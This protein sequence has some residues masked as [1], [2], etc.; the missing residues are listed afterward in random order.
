VA[1]SGLYD[2]DIS[3]CHLAIMRQL[4]VRLGVQMP[5]LDNYLANKAD[6]RKSIAQNIYQSIDWGIVSHSDQVKSV[7]AAIL[8][9]AYGGK[10][11]TSPKVELSKLIDQDS[12][13]L[14][15]VRHPLVRSLNSEFNLAAKA[16]VASHATASGVITNALGVRSQFSLPKDYKRAISH[17]ITGVEAKALDAILQRWGDS[18]LLAIHDGWVMRESIPVE[19]FE[20]EIAQACGMRLR[21]EVEPIKAAQRCG[22]QG[23]A[24]N[25]EPFNLDINQH[26]TP[27]LGAKKKTSAPRCVGCLGGAGSGRA[28]SGAVPGRAGATLPGGLVVSSRPRWNL[29]PGYRGTYAKVGRPR[30]KG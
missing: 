11:S 30:S 26:L 17:I 23:C 28:V 29:P 9:L 6:T 18:V 25:P 4:A 20:D 2:Y 10:L 8:L 15:F 16:I 27:S 13:R 5:T 7:K 21:V 22:D 12:A 3:N 1:L 14:A 19:Q 24:P